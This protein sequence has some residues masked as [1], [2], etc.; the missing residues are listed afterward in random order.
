MGDE[1]DHC[2]KKNTQIKLREA[3]VT[4]SHLYGNFGVKDLLT[5]SAVVQNKRVH[6]QQ[7]FLQVIHRGKLLVAALTHILS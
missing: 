3:E 2:P 6:I 4:N 5:E 1:N 7:V